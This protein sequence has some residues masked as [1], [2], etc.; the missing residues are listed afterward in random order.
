MV[1]IDMEEIKKANYNQTILK[2]LIAG[3][4]T[5]FAYWNISEEYNEK[6]K[7]KYGEDFFEKTKEILT[8]KNLRNG[9]EEKIEVNGITNNYYIRF[10]YSNSIYQVELS[11]IGINDNKDYGYKIISNQVV[12]P[13]VKILLDNYDDKNIKFKNIKNNGEYSE[14]KYYKK[15]KDNKD[16]IEKLYSEQIIPAWND[17]KK[18]NGYREK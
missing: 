18:E 6:F 15:D 13:N 1:K 5:I 7:K 8:L 3:I 4:D 10:K 16:K 14:T 2:I 11:R 9:K 17:Y 12:T